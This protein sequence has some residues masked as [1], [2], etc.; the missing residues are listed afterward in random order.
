M[1]SLNSTLIPICCSIGGKGKEED[2]GEAIPSTYTYKDIDL[3]VTFKCTQ[4]FVLATF[5]SYSFI[6]KQTKHYN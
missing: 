5:Y 4:V 3:P 6:N 2:G 1:S